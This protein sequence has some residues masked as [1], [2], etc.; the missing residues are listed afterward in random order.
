MLV[1]KRKRLC[2]LSP[3]DI[4]IYR[5]VL[6]R[7]VGATQAL[8]NRDMNLHAVRYAVCSQTHSLFRFSKTARVFVPHK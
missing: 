3:G 5:S 8:Y 2:Q 6:M 1:M 7:V 4:F